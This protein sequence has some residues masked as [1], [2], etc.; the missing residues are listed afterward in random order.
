M[1][2]YKSFINILN[3]PLSTPQKKKRSDTIYKTIDS[4]YSLMS[5]Y[6]HDFWKNVLLVFTHADVSHGH[7][8]RHQSHKVA[9]KTRV[10]RALKEKY[11]LDFDLPMLWISTQKYVCGF[12]KG[13]GECDC[14][15]GHRYHSD[16]RR[17]LY[18][19]VVKRRHLPFCIDDSGPEQEE[20]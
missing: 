17:R 16:C 3:P 18:E 10:N 9:L 5:S 20:A 4:F 19:Q 6:P 8:N 7:T 15:T 1:H 11:G 12:L 13:L 2:T 14:E